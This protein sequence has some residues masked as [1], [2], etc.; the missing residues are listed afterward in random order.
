MDSER[1]QVQGDGVVVVVV[2]K[3]LEGWLCRCLDGWEVM[4]LLVV[5][6]GLQ[7]ACLLRAQLDADKGVTGMRDAQQEISQH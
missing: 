4:E 7:R 1:E 2:P 3:H 6:D 5:G